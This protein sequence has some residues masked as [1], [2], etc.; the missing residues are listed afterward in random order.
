MPESPSF[1][2]I[3]PHYGAGRPSYSAELFAWLASVA[4]GRTLAWDVATGSGQA[5]IGLAA[6]FDAVLASDRS[7]QQIA[8]ARVHPKVHYRVAEAEDSG[9]APGSVDLVTVAAA[10][11]WFDRPAFYDEVSRVARP[12]AVLAAWTYHVA[13]LLP[14]FENLLW[15]FYRDV[16]GPHFLPGARMVDDRYE[17]I[18]LPGEALAAP[19]FIVTAHWDAAQLLAYVRTWSGTEACFATT[20]HDPVLSLAP[21]IER[22]L[23]RDRLH[24]LRWPIYLRAARVS[25]AVSA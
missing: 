2:S 8:H 15:T 11:H 1:D 7:A 5:A 21:A 24:A 18:D 20:G 4:P 16:V 25:A 19:E 22:A 3:A 9:C 17:G 6:H 12:G 13:Q 23:G 10:I 14:P